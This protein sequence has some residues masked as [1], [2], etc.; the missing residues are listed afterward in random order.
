M[1]M[2]ER[3]R[4]ART[5]MLLGAAGLTRLSESSVAVFG[6]GGV[7]SYAAEALA[8]AGIGTLTLID[9]DR[10]DTTNINRQIHALTETVGQEKTAAMGTRIRS[11]NPAC[12]V[13]GIAEFYQ[14]ENADA[15]FAHHYDYVVDAVD[16]V[17]AKIDLVRQCYARGIPVISS[18]GAANKLDPTLFEVLDIYRTK[19]DPIARIMRK[20]LKEY[21]IPH[22]KVVCSRERPRAVVGGQGTPVPGRR[23]VP[24]SVSFVPAAVGLIMAGAVVRD[25]VGIRVEVSA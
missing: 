9:H 20:K 12:A 24:G 10:I 5:E 2:D 23:S 1:T 15:F 25:L 16:T 17:S 11:I 22:L 7:G 21:G 3:G 6:I 8:R 19:A 13:T 4:F 14:P 18:M